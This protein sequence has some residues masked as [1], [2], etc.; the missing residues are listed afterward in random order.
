MGKKEELQKY[1]TAGQSFVESF[2][3]TRV[4]V[5]GMGGNPTAA[6]FNEVAKHASDLATKAKV[7]AGLCQRAEE[8]NPADPKDIKFA[9]TGID[10]TAQQV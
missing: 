6:A 8:G 9:P 7:C 3:H 2:N 4:A 1:A 5:M 10:P